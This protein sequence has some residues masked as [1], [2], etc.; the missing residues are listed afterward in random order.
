[1]PLNIHD[2]PQNC[3]LFLI[4]YLFI[5]SAVA[6]D[7]LEKVERN[8]HINLKVVSIC[9]ALLKMKHPKLKKCIPSLNGNSLS[10]ISWYFTTLHHLRQGSR[11]EVRQLVAC[12]CLLKVGFFYGLFLLLYQDQLSPVMNATLQNG[13]Y[14]EN[15]PGRFNLVIPIFIA[16]SHTL[17]E[18][19]YSTQ[20]HLCHQTIEGILLKSRNDFFLGPTTGTRS[21]IAFLRKLANIGRL[22]SK[23][24]YS[25]GVLFEC[26]ITFQ[27]QLVFLEYSL[28]S[29]C[30]G[31]LYFVISKLIGLIH[32]TAFLT[33]MHP[34]AVVINLGLL[35]I[36][37]FTIRLGQVHLFV[38]RH[39]AY[40]HT[41]LLHTFLAHNTVSLA[42][43]ESIN[44]LYGKVLFLVLL[45][46][47]PST[48][49]FIM[50][51][52]LLESALIFKV[53]LSMG[54]IIALFHMFILNYYLVRL[55][56][57]LHRPAKELIK[58]QLKTRSK[59]TLADKLKLTRYIEQF[60]TR[61]MYTF[62]YGK[63]GSC[64]FASFKK[65]LFYYLKLL[66][67]SYNFFIHMKT[68]K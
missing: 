37:S 36:V 60:H 8:I 14:L 23:V 45:I 49:V 67:F 15:L 28:F 54:I 6:K 20:V 25:V 55:S 58:I 68:D 47:L 27:A 53:S 7:F 4:F 59:Y 17:F 66:V 29:S 21:I 51:L 9:Q 2:L 35:T 40:F 13:L 34:F 41:K 63:F 33:L 24:A 44:A 62:K 42:F 11:R 48:A 19:M 10:F 5:Y 16:F 38:H 18:I 12:K 39:A 50:V 56:L 3:S 30:T 65:H 52:A 46:C 61:Q 64:T 57:K 22:L 1:M 31:W 32:L 26:G 43:L